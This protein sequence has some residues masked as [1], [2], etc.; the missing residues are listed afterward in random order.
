VKGRQNFE[1]WTAR[2]MQ[3]ARDY[4][5]KAVA[6]DP[7]YA[8]A[9]AMLAITYLH[10][11]VGLTPKDAITKARENVEKAMSLDNTLGEVHTAAAQLRFVGDWDWS[12]AE[13]EFRQAILLNPKYPET[14]HMYSHYLMAMGRTNE[15]LTESKRYVK[16]DSVG[17][18]PPLHLGWHYWMT[19]QYD[20]AIEQELKA[21][22]RD[23]NVAEVY[24]HLSQAYL[25]IGRYQQAIDALNKALELSDGAKYYKGLLGHAYAVAG[26]R[27]EAREVIEDLKRSNLIDSVPYPVA[28]IYAAL[29]DKDLAFQWLRKAYEDRALE[30]LGMA[31]YIKVDPAFDSLRSDTRFT[32]LLR[33]MNLER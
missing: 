26:R 11:N 22:E 19:R 27:V 24:R 29:G 12:G 20:L 30:T 17:F 16:L 3:R 4:F 8:A 7:N 2:D 21:K 15:S 10:G 23:G 6:K 9:Y 28:A 32:A 25:Y 31:V 33:K 18:S 13:K 5:E 14:H 1:R